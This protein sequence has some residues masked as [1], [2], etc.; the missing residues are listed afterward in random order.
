MDDQ[1]SRTIA[2][3]AEDLLQ[4]FLDINPIGATLL[5][6]RDRDDRLPDYRE[7]AHDQ[8]RTRLTGIAKTVDA[9]DD[10][11]VTGQDNITRAVVAHLAHAGLRELDTRAVEYT[12]TDAMFAPAA[13]LLSMLPMVT[14]TE[15]TQAEAYLTRLRQVPAVLAAIAERHRIGIA[16]GRVPVRPLVDATVTFLDRY[17]ADPPLRRPQPE[18][19]DAQF[20]TQRDRLLDDVVAPAI[21]AYRDVLANEVAAHSR[22]PEQ[23]GMCWLPDGESYYA[24]LVWNHTT[25]SRTPDEL[26]RTGE[27]I[28]AQLREEYAEIGSRVFGT[29]DVAAI[30]DR[31]RNDPALRWR[32]GDELLEAA[33]SAIRRAEEAAP[34]WFGSLPAHGCAVQAVPEVEAPGAPPAYYLPP[35][36]DGSR[37]GTYFAN[38]HLA[39]DRYRFVAETTAFHEA[40]PGHHFQI[41]RSQQLTDLPMVRR[42]SPFTAYTEGW[43]LYAERLADE[44]GL[45]SDDLARLGML[46]EDSARAA[47]LVVDTGLHAKGWS[48]QQVVD[49]LSARTLLSPLEAN[50]EADRYIAMPGQALAY[51][52]GRLEIQRIR[53]DAQRALGDRFNI[54]A[55]HDTVLDVG[56][57]PLTTLETLVREWTRNS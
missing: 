37:P 14:I 18:P 29:T 50:T 43:G 5:G 38:T 4:V 22:P 45:Y 52:V 46:T 3:A 12:V 7:E 31:L 27:E 13:E 49:Y 48:R 15:P 11:A 17:L 42:L 21:R 9:V 40:V 44:M 30:V 16:A 53:G 24:G 1:S 47:R 36:L 19:A 28:L 25:T 23:P 2:Q 41:S 56:A 6:L 8:L 35:A 54:G 10:N 51:M 32:D 57:V 34:A 26:H 20:H 33:R 39:A 55:F